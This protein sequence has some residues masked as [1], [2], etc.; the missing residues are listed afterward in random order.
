M[1]DRPGTYGH[2]TYQFDWER[3]WR[4]RGN[5]GFESSDVAFLLIPEGLHSTARAF[6][7]KA[8]QENI[9]PAY[10]CPYIDPSWERDRILGAL[11]STG[12]VGP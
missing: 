4:H 2:S 3:E 7:L 5:L 9:G 1:I 10:F 12:N 6:F 11:K 8:E